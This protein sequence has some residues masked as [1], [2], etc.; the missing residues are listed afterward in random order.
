MQSAGCE[1]DAIVYNAIIDALWDTGVLWAQKKALALFKQVCGGCWC[2]LCWS[3]K[4]EWQLR[5]WGMYAFL[6]SLGGLFTALRWR[7]FVHTTV[8]VMHSPGHRAPLHA[9]SV[10][11]VMQDCVYIL[12]AAWDRTLPLCAH[13]HY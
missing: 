13:C 6:G 1:P 3:H 11:Q 9:A 7:Q 12:H 5:M 4:R 8:C 10:I 2:M